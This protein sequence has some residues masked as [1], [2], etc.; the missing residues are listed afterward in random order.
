MT[1]LSEMVSSFQDVYFIIKAHMKECPYSDVQVSQFL[2]HEGPTKAA[3][4]THG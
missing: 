2:W 1:P 4:G 3:G